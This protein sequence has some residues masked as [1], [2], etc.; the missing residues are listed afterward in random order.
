M[1][2]QSSDDH[3]RAIGPNDIDPQSNQV[4]HRR[5]IKDL[6]HGDN[7]VAESVNLVDQPLVQAGMLNVKRIGTSRPEHMDWIDGVGIRENAGLYSGEQS[8]GFQQPPVK[9]RGEANTIWKKPHLAD[10]AGRMFLRSASLQLD[11]YE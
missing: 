8:L 11:L 1:L 3:I 2:F 4:V 9:E 6:A 7:P 10:D 5:F